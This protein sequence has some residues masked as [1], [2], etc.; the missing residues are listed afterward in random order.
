ML[1]RVVTAKR[2]AAN[3]WPPFSRTNNYD[4]PRTRTPGFGLRVSAC[5]TSPPELRG[6]AQTAARAQTGRNVRCGRTGDSSVTWLPPV[7][8]DNKISNQVTIPSPDEARPLPSLGAELATVGYLVPPVLRDN[9]IS[10]QVTVRSPDRPVPRGRRRQPRL[11]HVGGQ[12]K[13]ASR[14][15]PGTPPKWASPP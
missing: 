3:F 8:R 14:A 12:S 6:T 9:K 13:T 15:L 10:N 7:L 5:Q 1:R 2:P 11:R 4:S